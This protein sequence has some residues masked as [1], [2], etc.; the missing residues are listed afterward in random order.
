MSVMRI[1]HTADWHLNDR[2]GRI[3]RTEDLRRAVER[4]GAY[5]LEEKVDVLLVAGD[6][7]SELARPD[8]LRETIQHWQEV[9]SSFLAGGG[10]ILTITGNHDNE[11]F[12]R[13]L[14]HAMTLAAPL[15]GTPG[16]RVPHGRLYLASEPTLLKL[17]D[18]SDQFDVQFVLMPFPTPTRYFQAEEARKYS[19]P[20]EKNQLLTL[21]FNQAHADIRALPQFDANLRSVLV[22]HITMQGSN[23]GKGLF[24]LSDQEDIVIHGDKL[25][26]QYDYVALGHIHKPQYLAH[27]HVRYP[28]SIEHLDLGEQHNLTGVILFEIQPQGL[29]SEPSILPL[30]A[31]P[32]YELHL[33]NPTEDLPRLREEYPDAANDLVNLHIHYTPGVDN[34]EEILHETEKI[35]PR[36]YARDWLQTNAL[37]ETLNAGDA[38]KSKSFREIVVGYV[39]KELEN[40]LED[41]R[42]I[43]LKR[44]EELL[45]ECE[46]EELK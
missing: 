12:C 3:S 29:A 26:T 33:L 1:L 19:T 16:E 5:C 32:I 39:E 41:Q 8:D 6:L 2:L 13:T 35:F 43:L 15:S 25:H 9:F 22:A 31:T 42:A 44:L 36:W 11:N 21:A 38:D 18:P 27:T 28:G 23:L 46:P 10:T 34:L 30:Q 14:Q 7:F 17:R 37:G 40:D 24:R 20:S 4:I 45:Q